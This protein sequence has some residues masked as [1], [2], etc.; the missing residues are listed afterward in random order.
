[1]L[2]GASMHREDYGCNFPYCDSDFDKTDG[3]KVAIV[4][5]GNILAF[6]ATHSTRLSREG[7]KLRALAEIHA[8]QKKAEDAPMNQRKLTCEHTFIQS[9]K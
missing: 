4:K 9:L 7:I 1:M 3:A 2:G 5:D 6:C 8:E